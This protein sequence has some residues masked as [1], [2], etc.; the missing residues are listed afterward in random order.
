MSRW[1]SI[2]GASRPTAPVRSRTRS[3]SGSGA[4]S[5]VAIREKALWRLL[6]ETAARASEVL[7]LDV[8]DVDLENRRAVVRSKGGDIELLHFQ[9]GSARMLPRLIAGSALARREAMD[10]GGEMESW[11]KQMRAQALIGVGR[12]EEAIEVAEEAVRKSGDRGMLWSFPIAN[13]VLARA[14]VAAGRD[15]VREA[16]DEAERVAEQIG[17]TSLL[18]DIGKERAALGAGAR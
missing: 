3:L 16:L 13:L 10:N 1:V 2:V 17:A 4:R 18:N 7:S 15:G 8:G 11:R 12:A 14:R 9:T 5:D 6:Y